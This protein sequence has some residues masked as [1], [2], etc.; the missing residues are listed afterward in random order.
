MTSVLIRTGNRL[1][2]VHTAFI[3]F[4]KL[5]IRALHLLAISANESD[6]HDGV[7]SEPVE[8]NFIPK[9]FY[10]AFYRVTA[11]C[12]PSSSQ[13]SA[14]ASEIHFAR[15]LLLFDAAG[16]PSALVPARTVL[17]RNRN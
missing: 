14:E 10:R 9:I 4:N 17:L 15:E 11:I 2:I 7:Q 12:L 5:K 6:S 1:A 3:L 16:T 13:S 8:R